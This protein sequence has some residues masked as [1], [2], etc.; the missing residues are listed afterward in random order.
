MSAFFLV[1]LSAFSFGHMIMRDRIFKLVLMCTFLLPTLSMQAERIVL[2]SGKVIQGEIVLRNEEVIIIRQAN[3]TRFQYPTNEIQSIQQE[4]QETSDSSKEKQVETHKANPLTLRVQA[5]GG[6]LYVPFLGW[7]G[8]IG[9]DV[10][11]GSHIINGKCIFIGGG[12]GYRAK[13]LSDSHQ[14]QFLPLQAAILAPLTDGKHAPMAGISIGYGFSANKQAKGGIC[15]G[16]DFGWQYN[17]NTNFYLQLGLYAEWQ[18]AQ[19]D[20]I[21]TINNHE[22]TNNIGCN[23][24]TLGSKISI[25]F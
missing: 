9:A 11:I 15:L 2:H 17:V 8:Q 4:A 10:M 13:I 20:I 1:P 18:Q 21:E 16:A 24:I 12:V 3:G 22:Y 25:N 5:N 6:A 19:I 23:F 7:G 14:Y